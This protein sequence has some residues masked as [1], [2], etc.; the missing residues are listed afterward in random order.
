MTLRR[1]T[2]EDSPIWWFRRNHRSK[3]RRPASSDSPLKKDVLTPAARRSKLAPSGFHLAAR[4]PQFSGFHNYCPKFP[5][6]LEATLHNLGADQRIVYMP[7]SHV[8]SQLCNRAYA[9]LAG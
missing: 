6:D 1:S 2:A 4:T 8:W 3:R 9:P 5:Y 7:L